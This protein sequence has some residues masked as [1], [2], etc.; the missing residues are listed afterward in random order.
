[1]QW[2]L[3]EIDRFWMQ[4]SKK[5]LNGRSQDRACI[6]RSV[7]MRKQPIHQ[8]LNTSFVNLAALVRFLRGLQF[9]GSIRIELSSYDA[10]IIFSGSGQP[11]GREHDHIADRISEGEHALQRILIRAKE[12]CGRI[13]V[14]EGSQHFEEIEDEGV[15][16][17]AAISNGAKRMALGLSDAPVKHLLARIAKSTAERAD[18]NWNT[19]LDLTSELLQTIDDALAKA[20]L[21]FADAFANACTQVAATHPFLEPSSSSFRYKD[22]EILMDDRVD[23]KL[24]VSGIG[25]ALRSIFDRLRATPNLT[26]VHIYTIHRVRA[27]ALERKRL[28]ERFA[29]SQELDG[30]LGPR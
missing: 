29:L 9:V 22:G 1:M 28:Y 20:N 24:L 16:V 2:K 30:L 6:G 27:L 12:P 19:V 17:D 15:F 18:D 10:D 13:H 5:I 14:F 25:E 23:E 11:R 26:K 3:S 8:N 4:S 7:S 21:S